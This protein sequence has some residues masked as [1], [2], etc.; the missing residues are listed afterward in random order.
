MGGS[1][2]IILLEIDKVMINQFIEIE[3]V[4]YYSVAGFIA[5]VIA[6]PSRSMHQ[7][8]YPLTAALLNKGDIT[9]LK[10]LYQRSSLTLYI[11]SGLLFILILLNLDDL[12]KMLPDA[13]RNGFCNF[14]L[15]RV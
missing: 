13:Y 4:A 9:A 15:V 1:A 8:T 7:I 12:Y 14:C 6:V 5:M 10:A 11:I 3:N 2:A